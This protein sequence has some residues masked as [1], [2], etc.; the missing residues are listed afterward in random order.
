MP[1]L[2]VNRC[3]DRVSKTTATELLPRLEFSDRTDVNEPLEYA[4]KDVSS[5]AAV[6]VHNLCYALSKLMFEVHSSFVD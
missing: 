6:F 3:V 2:S 5:D 1:R 4:R